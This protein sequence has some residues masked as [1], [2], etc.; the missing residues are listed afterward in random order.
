MSNVVSPP[1]IAPASRP[2]A[3]QATAPPERDNDEVRK[4][5]GLKSRIP[6]PL[7]GHGDDQSPHYP[8]VPG[9]TER[10]PAHSVDAAPQRVVRS[11]PLLVL[12]L[13]AAIAVWAGWVGIGRMTGFGQVH[14]L[15]G[16]WPSFHLNTAVT[17]PVGVEAY[18]A[19]A[20]RAWLSA[21]GAVSVR[22]RRFA[23]W[24]AI[25][26]L[27]LGMAGQVSYHLLAQA[28]VTRAPW[29]VTTV[30]SCLPVMVLGMGAA[31]AHLLHADAARLSALAQLPVIGRGDDDLLND[32][33]AHLRVRPDRVAE[34]QATATVVSAAG[35]RVSRRTLRAA[36][37]R[38]SNAELGVLARMVAPS[39][40]GTGPAG[41][42]LPDLTQRVAG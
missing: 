11:W 30:V 2:P 4:L 25:G 13:P 8:R 34:A 7:A 32:G 36:G 16:I 18:A 9:R 6:E 12:A 21:S 27:M 17:L 33:I 19:Y 31:L 41:S 10:T 40:D 22:T 24:S 39:R 29:G 42:H 3:S 37:L 28:H 5:V 1:K 26:S 15:P 20:L 14:P 23:R 38:G 35:H